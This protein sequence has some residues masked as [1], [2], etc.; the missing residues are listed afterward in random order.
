MK[1]NKIIFILTGFVL[2]TGIFFTACNT[3]AQ[4][5]EKAKEDVD[6]A[7]KNLEAANEAYL[8]DVENYRKETAEKIAANDRSIAEFNTRIEN[9]KADAKADY[10][11]KIMELEQK[12]TDMKKTMNDYKAEGKEQWENFKNDFNRNMD[13]LG[14]AL[15][16]LT[17]KDKNK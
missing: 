14:N 12:N 10:K 15:E 11:R 1:K 16:D 7:N 5:V 4:N 8:A 2:A 3:P 9:E 13:E 17:T 6:A